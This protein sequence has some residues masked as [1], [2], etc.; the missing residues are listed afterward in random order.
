MLIRLAFSL[1]A[2]DSLEPI[3]SLQAIGLGIEG[4][5]AGHS[6]GQP[7]RDTDPTNLTLE[8]AHETCDYLFA[9]INPDIGSSEDT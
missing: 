3:T 5:P 4:A 6:A 8:S 7:G 1:L 2:H 9:P